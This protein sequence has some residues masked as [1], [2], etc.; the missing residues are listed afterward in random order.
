MSEAP[1]EYFDYYQDYHSFWPYGPGLPD[2]VLQKVYY[3]RALRVVKGLPT[4]GW[5]QSRR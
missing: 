4:T 1:D 2:A 5:P 3:P